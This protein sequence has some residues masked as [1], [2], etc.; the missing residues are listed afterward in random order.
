MNTNPRAGRGFTLVELMVTVAIAA[1]LLGFALPAFNDFVMQRRITTTA[2]DFVLAMNYARSEAA[3]LGG[4]VSVQALNAADTDNEWGPGF[5]VVEGDPGNCN[6]P[7]RVFDVGFGDGTVDALDA[8]DGADTFSFNS[9]GMLTAGA[10][11][12]L[13]VCTTDVTIDPGRSLTISAVGRPSV[14]ELEC[15]P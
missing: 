11:G 3:R 8:L 14:N 1:V 4:I 13:E 6:D 10:A 12:V 2:N 15:H 7:L 9:R 5:C